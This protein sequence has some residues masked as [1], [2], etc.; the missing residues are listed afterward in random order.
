MSSELNFI[1]SLTDN[2]TRPLRAAGQSFSSFATSSQRAFGRIA[3][4]GAALWGVGAAISSTLGPAREMRRA[5]GEVESLG[6]DGTSL[7][8]LKDT[9][10]KFSIQYGESAADFVKS[11]YDIQSAIAGL[12]GKEL[13]T[14]TNASN[15]LA[16][17]TKSDAATITN[18]VGTM[19]GIFK[20]QADAMGKEAWVDS[21]AGQT[22]T[23]VR[24]FKTTG[25]EMSGAFTA[26]GAS[27]QSAGVGIA[28]QMAVLGTLQATMSG[29]EAGTKYKAFLAGVGGAQKKLGLNF[30]NSDGSMQGITQILT[31]I[32]GKFGD[33]S[34]VADS[35]KL[36]A[37]FG[38]DEAVA[39]IK[40]MIG[41]IDGLKGSMNELG[42]VNGLKQ[43]RE[44]A[45]AMIDPFDKFA[46][47]LKAIKIIIGDTLMPTVNQLM[48]SITGTGDTMLRWKK[49]FPHIAQ[50]IG[51]VV[52]G[53]ISF[54]AVG[55]T[56]NIIVGVSQFLWLGITRTWWLVNKVTK[57]NIALLW[58]KNTALKA[59]NFTMRMA[60][61]ITLA[62]SIA[63]WGFGAATNFA[64]WPVLA[65]IAAIAALAVGAYYLYTHWEEVKT[66]IANSSA[67]QALMT[68]V[69]AVGAVFTRVWQGIGAGWD[70][71]VSKFTGVS[72][73]QGFQNL[74][75]GIAGIFGQLWTWLENSISGVG[76]W[77]AEKLNKIP[78]VNIDT[79][80]DTGAPTLPPLQ[81]T[82][83][84]GGTVAPM[85]RGGLSGDIKGGS[86]GATDNRQQI[87]EV[88]FNV[89]NMPSPAQLHEWEGLKA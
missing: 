38:S 89:Q 67:F 33:L 81:A 63:T 29:S 62:L 5:L 30:T 64:L 51:L 49:M 75:T 85:P 66:S 71:L 37:A 2:V 47:H 83:L 26:L 70:W 27:A 32:R 6:V 86:A 48:N 8:V 22:A 7:N 15:V 24:M 79:G 19:Y 3:V 57:V 40:L 52:A 11:S 73:L 18:Y 76:T 23:A 50:A 72:L 68:V 34:K 46:Q 16:K 10:L 88:N 17:A 45:E 20:N 13:S 82:A 12:S 87:G 74:A 61:G 36:K 4:G 9:A 56:A 21:L 58:L 42:K 69:D 84:T 60:R 53:L 55:A 1:L 41:N 39:M 80:S 31:K 44:M 59:L 25:G 54:A 77:I 43:A 65:I 28:E 35:D 14:F 78:G